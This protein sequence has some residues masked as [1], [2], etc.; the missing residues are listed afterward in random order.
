M[1]VVGTYVL[2]RHYYERRMRQDKFVCQLSMGVTKIGYSFQ[3]NSYPM[4][5]YSLMLLFLCFFPPFYLPRE[6]QVRFR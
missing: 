2:A 1:A 4:V 3:L 6:A 5:K